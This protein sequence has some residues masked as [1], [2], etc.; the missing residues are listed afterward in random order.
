MSM[1]WSRTE[2]DP[3]HRCPAAL[4][5]A[6]NRPSRSDQAPAERVRVFDSTESPD[7]ILQEKGSADRDFRQN[8]QPDFEEFCRQ[9][10]PFGIFSRKTDY[11]P[12]NLCIE[13]PGCEALGDVVGPFNCLTF[14][15]AILH[16]CP[17]ARPYVQSMGT[18]LREVVIR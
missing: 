3:A 15:R 16:C 11:W 18:R 8:Q 4:V 17:T 13:F 12:S 6:S 10:R 14:V 1:T 7:P 5:A 9:I 2:T